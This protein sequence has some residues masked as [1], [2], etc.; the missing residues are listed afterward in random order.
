MLE[1][2][3][4]F[5][6]LRTP[7]NFDSISKFNNRRRFGFAEWFGIFDQHVP[8]VETDIII[9]VHTYLHITRP[10][11]FKSAIKFT[12]TVLGVIS[13][14]TEFNIPIIVALNLSIKQIYTVIVRVRELW[15]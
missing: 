9:N 14:I 1:V 3:S 6:F 10:H 12:Q 4:N 5:S 8:S 13:Y 7:F 11:F 2:R 15:I